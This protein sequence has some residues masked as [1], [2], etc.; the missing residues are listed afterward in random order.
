M[1]AYDDEI[2]KANEAAGEAAAPVQRNWL[3]EW[4]TDDCPNK[5]CIAGNVS[6]DDGK[7]TRLYRCPICDR[8]KIPSAAVYRGPIEEFTREE[9]EA[10]MRDRKDVYHDKELRYRRGMEIAGLLRE[11]FAEGARKLEARNAAGQGDPF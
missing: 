10:R 5:R 8:S 7:S 2:R 6:I 3:L 4:V 9:L 11:I 1:S